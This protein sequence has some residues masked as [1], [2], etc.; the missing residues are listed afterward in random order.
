MGTFYASGLLLAMILVSRVIS[1]NAEGKKE[2]GK[3]ETGKQTSKGI[4]V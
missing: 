1:I 4:S 3:K 2:T